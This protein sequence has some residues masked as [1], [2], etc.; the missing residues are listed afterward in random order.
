MQFRINSPTV[1]HETL[2]DEVVIVHFESGAY[3]SL[4]QTGAEIWNLLAAGHDVRD[5]TDFLMRRHP[6]DGAAIENAV[7]AFVESLR[8]EDLIAAG[9]TRPPSTDRLPADGD[10]TPESAADFVE[11]RLEKYSDM[12]DLL[13]LDPIHE[14]DADGWPHRKPEGENGPR[15]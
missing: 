13:L 5:I 12:Q 6:G 9:D 4:R 14:V 8:R 11:P 10:V 1:I 3:F 2:D 15:G 7:N